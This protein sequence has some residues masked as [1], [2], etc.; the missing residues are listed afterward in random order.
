M[1]LNVDMRQPAHQTT[2]SAEPSHPWVF[3]PNAVVDRPRVTAG[4]LPYS[5]WAECECPDDCPRD[6][7][8]E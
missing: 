1:E 3:G 2:G 5:S 4:G 6:H 7:E 8:N